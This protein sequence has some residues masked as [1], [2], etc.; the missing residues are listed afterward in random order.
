MM[1]DVSTR[2]SLESVHDL[3]AFCH[4]KLVHLVHQGERLAD[5]E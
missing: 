2:G 3:V 5:A 1:R 4:V